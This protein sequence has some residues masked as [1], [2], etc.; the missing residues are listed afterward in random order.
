MD[1]LR[2][3]VVSNIFAPHVRG[4]YELGCQQIAENFQSDGHQVT[5]ATSVAIGKLI[6]TAQE[7]TVP[8]QQI[9]EPV[10]D[11]EPNLQEFVSGHAALSARHRA[12]L[13]GVLESNIIAMV[14]CIREWQPDLIWVSNP[15]GLGP[16]G[17]L[18]AC[19]GSG[20]PCII[21]LMDDIDGVVVSH[22]VG[23]YLLPRYRRVKSAFH[24]IACSEKMAVSNTTA[25][26]FASLRIIYNGVDIPVSTSCAGSTPGPFRVVYFGQLEQPKGLLAAVR[27]FHEFLRRSSLPATLDLIGPG[28]QGFRQ[29]LTAEIARLG[30]TERVAFVGQLPRPELLARLP[31]YAAALLLLSDTEPFGYAPVEAGALGLPVIVTSGAGAVEWFP[32]DYPLIVQDRDSAAEVASKLNLVAEQPMLIQSA[33]AD[34]QDALRRHCDFSSVTLPAYRRALQSIPRRRPMPEQALFC[35]HRTANLYNAKYG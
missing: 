7:S 13:G 28:S 30:L 33:M 9:F 11:Y 32:Q 34:L 16:V 25:G 22:Q 27:G 31:N 24:A 8:V 17:I 1:D 26:S 14:S 3:L 10:F 20:V 19:A 6:R 29:I 35:S 18:E 15:I 23:Q 4:G 21:H 12:A 5:V 2:I